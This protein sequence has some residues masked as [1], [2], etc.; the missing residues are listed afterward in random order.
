[1][2]LSWKNFVPQDFTAAACSRI[3]TGFHFSRSIVNTLI[4]TFSTIALG[5]LV[6]SM[7]ALAFACFEFLFK[8]ILFAV[9]LM[10][11]MIPFEAIALPLY[12]IANGLG[13]VDTLRGMVIPCVANG[14]ALFLFTSFSKSCRWISLKRLTSTA[15]AGLR[16]FEKSS[17]RYQFPSPS[18]PR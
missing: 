11:F 13:F 6:N 4:V 8:R 17:C 18:Q 16:F 5:L 3:F 2:P 9:V 15:Q 14:L 7:A 10:T 1:M 12:Q